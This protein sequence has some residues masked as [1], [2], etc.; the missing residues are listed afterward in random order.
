[1]DAVRAKFATIR[2]WAVS[3][4][5]EEVTPGI[6]GISLP[7]P[8]RDGRPLASIG[9]A[10]LVDRS[11]APF[12][13]RTPDPL[14]KAVAFLR[15][16]A[17][18]TSLPEPDDV[19]RRHDR[20]PSGKEPK[21]MSTDIQEAQGFRDRNEIRDL[22]ENWVVWRDAGHWDRFRT[23]WHPDGVMMATWTQGTGE[24]FIEASIDGWN[25]GAS[26]LRFLGDQS[27]DIAGDRAISQAEMAISQRGM[28]DGSECAIV[29]TERFYDVL[30]K[31]DGRWGI[32]LRQPIYEEDAIFPV[33]PS[34][35]PDLDPAKLARFPV[36][37][38]HPAYLQEQVGYAIRT[39]MPGLKG[40]EVE[41]LYVR[42][43]T[44][45]AGEEARP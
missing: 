11:D 25:R 35:P 3:A 22:I 21:T 10:V 32:A 9:G 13:G 43:A 20:T 23:V 37:Y 36:G 14:Q 30:E 6:G 12:R 31:R 1:M 5:G 4:V 8:D 27:I 33:D 44:W 19:R 28:V 41:D 38:R 45:L 15:R 34:N 2:A 24:E 17:G 39:D 40:P 26:I 16:R 18:P 7:I 29:F 42:G